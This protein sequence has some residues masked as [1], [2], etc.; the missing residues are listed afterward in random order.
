M[1]SAF[2]SCV[3]LCRL[4]LFRADYSAIRQSLSAIWLMARQFLQ[5]FI[6]CVIINI[7]WSN[8]VKVSNFRLTPLPPASALIR[9]TKNRFGSISF[10]VDSL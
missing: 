4:L 10:D 5:M 7:A 6:I 9:Q 1:Q 3:Q 8:D 2:A